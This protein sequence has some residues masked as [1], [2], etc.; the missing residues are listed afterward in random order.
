MESWPRISRG[1]RRG[2]PT[3]PLIALAAV[4]AVFIPGAGGVIAAAQIGAGGGGGGDPSPAAGPAHPRLGDADDEAQAALASGGDARTSRSAIAPPDLKRRSVFPLPAKH[5][6][7][8]GLSA[9]R[10]HQGQ[11][12]ITKCGGRVLAAGAGRVRLRDYQGAAGY[13]LTIEGEATSRE[14]VYQHL[15]RRGRPRERTKVRAGQVIGFVGRSGNA[16]TCH[17]HFEI[18]TA[19]G[20]YIG[21]TAL[22]PAPRL[23][24][25]D[26]RR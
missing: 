3:G 18:W 14:Y 26:S 17:L 12:L 16:S 24:R 5:S 1:A 11:D 2:R 8:D 4:A 7:G 21:G 22:D 10:G 6:F 13:Y 23:R 19:P 15:V 9:G 20:S 25:W